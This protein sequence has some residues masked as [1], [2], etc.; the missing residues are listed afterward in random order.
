MEKIYQIYPL[1]CN[2]YKIRFTQVQVYLIKKRR[3]PLQLK[4]IIGHTEIVRRIKRQF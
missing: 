4:Y 3:K 1:H 2:N